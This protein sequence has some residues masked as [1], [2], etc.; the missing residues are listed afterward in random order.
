MATQTV[1]ISQ[2]CIE[3]SATH[4]RNKDGNVTRGSRCPVHAA[5]PIKSHTL[6]QTSS[7]TEN[8]GWFCKC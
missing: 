3:D 1:T 4:K 8:Q 2:P 6:G 5:V 7:L